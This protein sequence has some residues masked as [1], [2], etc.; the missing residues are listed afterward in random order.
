MPLFQGGR[1][2]R[3]TWFTVYTDVSAE[4]PPGGEAW[5]PNRVRVPAVLLVDPNGDP[6]TAS[7][8]G[9]GGSEYTESTD[10]LNG[11][12]GTLILGKVPSA[13]GVDPN[14][15]KALDLTVNIGTI[16][17]S[18]RGPLVYG[19]D[20]TAGGAA[21][22]SYPIRTDAQAAT[23]GSVWTMLVDSS[24]NQIETFAGSEY[25]E[26]VDAIA[27]Q[28]GII[29]LFKNSGG[30]VGEAGNLDAS[31][32]LLV[33]VA[34]GGTS[35]FT[36]KTAF[37]PASGEGSITM[38]YRDDATPSTLNEGEGGA[39]RATQHRGLHAN[40]RASDGTEIGKTG[41]NDGLDVHLKEIEAALPETSPVP[42]RLS[43]GTVFYQA[44]TNLQLP[45]SR[46]QQP[47]ANSLSVTPDSDLTTWPV[48]ATNLD[49]RDLTSGS[50]SVEVF[51]G[52]ASNLHARVVRA[53][54][55]ALLAEDTFTGHIGE[56][57]ASPTANTVLDRLRAINA[58]Q[59]ATGHDI[60][61][62]GRS[63][64]GADSDWS[65][66]YTFEDSLDPT[67]AP[68]PDEPGANQFIANSTA[69]NLVTRL[70]FH[71][72]PVAGDDVGR[73]LANVKK[74]S[75]I[76]IQSQ[77][78]YGGSWGRYTVSDI[79]NLT[80]SIWSVDVV[81]KDGGSAFIDAVDHTVMFRKP[82]T[83]SSLI[84]GSTA[85]G[86]VSTSVS[87]AFSEADVGHVLSGEV[88]VADS[89]VW[90]HQ[91]AAFGAGQNGK[92]R[93]TGTYDQMEINIDD[94]SGQDEEEL[95]S[96]LAIGDE[97]A[98][99]D[100]SAVRQSLRFSVT[101]STPTS[102]YYVIGLR[103]LGRTV[104]VP[105]N[106]A[107]Y[108][109]VVTKAAGLPGI[110]L[111]TTVGSQEQVTVTSS[112]SQALIG[113]NFDRRRLFIQ[114][115]GRSKVYVYKGTPAVAANTPI[116]LNP[117]GSFIEQPD[118]LGFLYTGEF[119]AIVEPGGVDCEVGVGEETV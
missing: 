2:P 23:R 101:G 27:G 117:G 75:T 107:D 3:D 86:A 74:N 94:L 4:T 68:T 76:I 35:G 18:T 12:E 91:T 32:N 118:N 43:D 72:S 106:G 46:G 81:Y 119:T 37:S 67:A 1:G 14:V 96:T 114:N 44:P 102:D 10:T 52:T 36:D 25:T 40:L 16:D 87:H 53:D 97:I 11:E 105:A 55:S 65:A 48:T 66:T 98:L 7:G 30:S 62:R 61:Q 19:A 113:Q 38:A 26:G 82:Q 104:G 78:N 90:T 93:L 49:I 6:Y 85:D 64:E 24:G 51:Q 89:Y 17:N 39:L 31:G 54:D 15:A 110:P 80:A 83:G 58:A 103:L 5:D 115:H 79:V 108:R 71:F 112:G 59:L 29:A 47:Q 56:V 42:A 116:R 63:A 109:F 9:G 41:L 88:N 22:T 33:N 84:L 92:F 13:A 21:T 100:V 8:G 28:E 60:Y 34:A 111:S 73:F 50:D 69:P 99:H 20:F 95:I 57:S 77:T 45:P 70:A